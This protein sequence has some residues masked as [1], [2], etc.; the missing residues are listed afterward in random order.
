MS[1]NFELLQQFGKEP[2]AFSSPT[3][4]PQEPEIFA[5]PASSVPSPSQLDNAGTEEIK[6]LVQRVFLL[7]AGQAP[8]IVV[9]A[10]SESGDGCSWIC[11]RAAEA[12]ARQVSGSV[13]L[14]DANLRAPGLHQQFEIPNHHGLSDALLQNEPMATF[15]TALSPANLSMVSCGSAPE[16]LQELLT[17]NRMRSR[18]K[19]LRA[20]FDYVLVDA[21]AMNSS[22]DAIVL[23]AVSDGAILV[24][25]ANSSR[26]ETARNAVQE[27]QAAKVRVLGAVLNRRTFP[28]PEAIYNKL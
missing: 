10:G 3:L 26:K 9:F 24:L 7:S 12:L 13:C 2:E 14:V 23:G 28:I 6:T 20:M 11:A 25:K 4:T 21:S 19:E 16:G 8:H 15:V 27:F 22:N 18:L 1:R 17:S 5:E